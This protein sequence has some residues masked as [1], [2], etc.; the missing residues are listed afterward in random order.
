MFFNTRLN[1]KFSFF[2]MKAILFSFMT[3]MPVITMAEIT[4]T[5]A[6]SPEAPPVSK[7]MAGYMDIKN[8]SA[9]HEHIFSASSPLFKK[10]EIHRTEHKNG[11]MRML[12][13]DDLYLPGHD[14]VRLHSGGLHMMLIGK[15]QPIKK[16]DVIPVTLDFG[17]NRTQLIKLEVKEPSASDMHQHHH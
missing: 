12:K 15:K 6:W 1:N 5:N 17:N 16:G 13:E 9:H 14:T 4:V 11:M 2:S 7:V 8:N 10:V 3:L